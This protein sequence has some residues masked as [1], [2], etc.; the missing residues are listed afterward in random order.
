MMSSPP[1][2]PPDAERRRDGPHRV[3]GTVP[4]ILC[5][6]IEPDERDLSEH[7]DSVASWRA[8]DEC[9]QVITALRDA[10][11]Q[12]T[13]SRV[14]LNWFWRADPQILKTFGTADFALA[15]F[16]NRIQDEGDPDDEHGNHPHAWRWS[17]SEGRWFNDCDNADWITHCVH[18]SHDTLI[19]ALPRR[20]TCVRFGDRWTSAAAVKEFVALGYRFELTP[21][22]GH[23][24]IPMSASEPLSTG[25]LPD[26][27]KTPTRPYFPSLDNPSV[28]A[29]WGRAGP[30]L[31]IPV[32]THRFRWLT[33]RYPFLWSALCTLN[34]ASPSGVVRDILGAVLRRQRSP[35]VAVMR[36]GD[37]ARYRAPIEENLREVFGRDDLRFVTPHTYESERGAF[38]AHE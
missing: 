7:V 4:L 8:T 6:D 13:G 12:S 37:F 11:Q 10:R 24:R 31:T 21:E 32:T 35:L 16:L 29:R 23:P 25:A 3:E 2:V 14:L 5:V 17:E 38:A 28:A 9:L 22:P 27:R 26:Y 34:L 19:Q 18:A 15:R 20:P 33:R 30:L 1:P 36:S